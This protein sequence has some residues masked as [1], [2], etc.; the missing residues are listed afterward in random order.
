MSVEYAYDGTADES[1]P[2]RLA[3][4]GQIL[5][6]RAFGSHDLSA[7]VR[8]RCARPLRRGC[9]GGRRTSHQESEERG[10]R[11]P[12][13]RR[14]KPC[15]QRAPFREHGRDDGPEGGED[16]GRRK[17][18]AAKEAREKGG[19]EELHVGQDAALASASAAASETCTVLSRCRIGAP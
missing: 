5:A 11:G 7:G 2:G 18:R 10:Q 14:T 9:R 4:S 6:D 8:R 3:R 16:S 15:D 17:R 19:D 13:I 1:E 12:T